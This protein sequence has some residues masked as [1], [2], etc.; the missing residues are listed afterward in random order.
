MVEICCTSRSCSDGHFEHSAVPRRSWQRMRWCFGC[1][2]LH[3][4]MKRCAAVENQQANAE[5]F[6]P[7]ADP[8]DPPGLDNGAMGSMACDPFDPPGLDDDAR[9]QSKPPSLD[10]GASDRDKRSTHLDSCVVSWVRQF[11]P[12][13][14]RRWARMSD[15]RLSVRYG[16]IFSGTDIGALASRSVVFACAGAGGGTCLAKQSVLSCR[17]QRG[18]GS[19]NDS[20]AIVQSTEGYV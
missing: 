8:F 5:A 11:R 10:D 6:R 14:E 13:L 12:M 4:V 2:V 9:D 18:R 17:R 7:M 19:R 1:G 3:V 20:F 16:S 15:A